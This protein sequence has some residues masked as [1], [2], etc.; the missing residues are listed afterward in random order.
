MA[1]GSESAHADRQALRTARREGRLD[2][3]LL[4]LA[5]ASVV[6]SLVVR[7]WFRGSD[8]PGWDLLLTAEGQY[9][10]ATRGL[11]AA[12][13]ETLVQVRTFWLPPAAYSVPYGLLPGALTRWWPGIFWQ[14]LVVFLAWMAT[15]ALLLVAMGWPLRSARG[16][17]LALLAWGASPALLSYAVEG[18]PWGAGLLPH[19]L[20]LAVVFARS[21]RRWWVTLLALGLVWELPFHG[22]EL[23]KTAGTT[24]VVAAAL[25]PEAG[26]LRRLAWAVTGASQQL[27]VVWLWPSSNIIAFGRG[28]SG[29]GVGLVHA[30]PLLPDGVEKLARAMTGN[31]PLIVPVLA[32]AG[33]LALWWAGRAR[34]VLVATWAFQLGLVL[35]LAA[36]QQHGEDLLRARRFLLVDGLS[37]AAV[38][39]AGRN[40]RAP[41]RGLLI[42]LLLAGNAWSLWDLARFVTAPRGPT[43]FTLPDVFS[44]EGVGLVDRPGVAWAEGLAR[45][46]RAGER[47]VVLHGQACPTETFT[48]PTGVLERL[49]L[50]LGPGAFRAR[51]VA[52]GVPQPRYVTVPVVDLRHVLGTLRPGQ[53]ID[54]DTSCSGVYAAVWR[55]LEQRFALTPV[56]DLPAG[57]FQQFRLERATETHATGPSSKLLVPL[58][59]VATT[60]AS[61][62]RGGGPGEPGAPSLQ[63]S[64]ERSPHERLTRSWS[65]RNAR[66]RP[67]SW[68]ARRIGRPPL[69]RSARE[70]IAIRVDRDRKYEMGD[71][72][73][74]CFYDLPRLPTVRRGAARHGTGI[75][76]RVTRRRQIPRRHVQVVIA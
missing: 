27:A 11:W 52:L 42:A 70:L 76:A 56:G 8:V 15:L 25:A 6:G 65:G 50:R 21:F 64:M 71:E 30:L 62:D 45:R 59:P 33:G 49:Y 9:L 75:G 37:V 57:R 38:L 36:G 60:Q 58:G 23:G 28:N 55:K 51:I 72:D 73:D 39:A 67:S 24:L 1:P 19:A 3:G 17:M 20:A 31:P 22:Y 32:V 40:D 61:S 10:L 29:A 63:A 53:V 43:A 7:V 74:G 44:A 12:L 46:A 2:R 66:S 69:G 41:V 13:R 48:N 34:P 54:L 18:Y 47:V 68:L 26:W 5:L 14:P 16:W 35:V 4:M